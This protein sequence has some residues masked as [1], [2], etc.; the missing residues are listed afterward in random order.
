MN[1]RQAEAEPRPR[2]EKAFYFQSV[3]GGKPFARLALRLGNFRR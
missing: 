1:G 3:S 2:P